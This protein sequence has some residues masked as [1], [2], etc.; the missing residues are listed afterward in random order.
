MN[1]QAATRAVKMTGSGKGGSAS[2]A[3][4]QSH[5]L[6]IGINDYRNGIR[7]LKT[8][9]NDARRLATI[10]EQ[11][12]GYTVHLA[13]E[14]VSKARLKVLLTEELQLDRDDRLLVYFAGHGVA[15]DG[16][17]GPQGYLL[18][19]DAD[20]ADQTTLLPM[21][22]L[23]DWLEA[24]PCRHMLAI[25]DCCFAGAFRWAATPRCQSHDAGSDPQR[26]L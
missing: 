11:D 10:L 22:D 3:F 1:E 17:D 13:V 18:L 6:I 21:T 19:E 24:L 15:L 2:K 12:H 26:T 4:R 7:P 16:E 23:H 8:A 9:V 14:D 20:S 5:A 25:F